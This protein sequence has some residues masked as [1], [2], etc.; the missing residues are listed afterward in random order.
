MQNMFFPLNCTTIN[1]KSG[2]LKLLYTPPY[3]SYLC[4]AQIQ[5]F[6]AL[7]QS[8]FSIYSPSHLIWNSS[9]LLDLHKWFWITTYTSCPPTFASL[10]LHRRFGPSAPS[11][12]QAS[13]SRT[14]SLQSIWLTL[15]TWVCP[16]SQVLLWPLLAWCEQS[17]QWPCLDPQARV[18]FS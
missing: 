1:P 16:S 14:P 13:L 9:F 4:L 8:I 12:A 6:D 11:L 15:H 5:Q 3:V 2:Y 7:K 18:S 17:N 10:A